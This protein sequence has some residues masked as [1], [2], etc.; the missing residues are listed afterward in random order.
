MTVSLIITDTHTQSYLPE[1]LCVCWLKKALN[2]V[3]RSQSSSGNDSCSKSGGGCNNICGCKNNSSS[4]S[5]CII[6]DAAII[7]VI[8]A[9]VATVEVVV[10]LVK[11]GG[12]YRILKY[13]HFT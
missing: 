2:C 5:I 8:V 10:V 1:L 6:I 13:S 9:V 11:L 7:T 12:V 3:L 4:I